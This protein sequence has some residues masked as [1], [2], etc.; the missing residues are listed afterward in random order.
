VVPEKARAL[1]A[2]FDERSQHYEIR[3]AG[4]GKGK[5]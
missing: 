2:H 3:V 5:A 4:K 1:L